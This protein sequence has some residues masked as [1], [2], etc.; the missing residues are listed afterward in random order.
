MAGSSAVVRWSGDLDPGARGKLACEAGQ[1][2]GKTMNDSAN[3][4]GISAQ[5]VQTHLRRCKQKL[6]ASNTTHAVS[7]AM[8]HG[9]I[10]V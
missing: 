6:A 10:D 7:K 8:Y 1:P 3:I 9:L 4:L 5:T 2:G